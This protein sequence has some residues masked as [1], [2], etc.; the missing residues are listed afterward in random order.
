MSELEE[1]LK[2]IKRLRLENAELK[3]RLG[4]PRNR[5][6]RPRMSR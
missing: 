5:A 6:R 1:A 2:E 4:L 3:R